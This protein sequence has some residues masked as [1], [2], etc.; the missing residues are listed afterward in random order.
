MHIAVVGAGSWG[1]AFASHLA[2][3][4][5]DVVLLAR[6][7]AQAAV[8]AAER[9][10]QRYLPDVP[11][12]AGV[13]V[14]PLAEGVDPA[15]ELVV[16]AVPSR[17]FGAVLA[18]LAVPAGAAVLSLTKGLEPGTGRR[19]SEVAAGRVGDAG[20]V[21]VLSGPNHA[22]EIARG[23]PAATVI[24]S[25]SLPLAERLQEAVSSP[26]LRVYANADVAASS[27]AAPRRT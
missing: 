26:L 12:A 16:L 4:G 7:P 27:C 18:G 15:A 5:H 11:I 24:A 6:D 8:M 2:G 13:R 17:A 9:V 10:N 3:N 19:L 20:R 25:S 23:T 21:A 22:E 1:T 14:A